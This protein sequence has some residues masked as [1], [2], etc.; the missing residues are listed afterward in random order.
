MQSVTFESRT[1]M[2]TVS[3]LP[4]SCLS[5]DRHDYVEVYLNGKNFCAKNKILGIKY[6]RQATEL[7]LKEAKDA[8]ETYGMVYLGSMPLATARIFG[9]ALE[10]DGFESPLWGRN[11][12]SVP[13]YEALLSHNDEGKAFLFEIREDTDH[14]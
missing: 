14:E 9:A 11:V 7:G 3:L 4:V 6:I 2:A 10:R 12:V 13:Y 1:P 5:G 8:I